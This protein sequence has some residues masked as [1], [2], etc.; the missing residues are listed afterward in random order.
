MPMRLEV[1]P[2]DLAGVRVGPALG[3]FAETLLALGV[4]RSPRTPLRLHG[5]WEAIAPSVTGPERALASYL[6]LSASVGL[7]LFT[8]LPPTATVSEGRAALA[9]AAPDVLATE[10]DTWAHTRDHAR[11]LGL[12]P[13][14]GP[15][16]RLALAALRDGHGA[17]RDALISTIA[18]FHRSGLA[19]Y[20]P[21]VD[22]QLARE[23]ARL[24]EQLS[25]GG[26]QALV[27]SMGPAVRW[28]ESSIDF[29]LVGVT[30]ACVNRRSLGGRG[31]VV[32]PSFFA[33]EPATYWPADA[34][35][36]VLLIVPVALIDRASL[37]HT[38]GTPQPGA[39]LLG[40]TRAAILEA[41]ARGPRSTSELGAELGIAVSGASQH[42][43]VLR[44]AGLITS[45]RDGGRVLH[46]TT[47]LGETL[48]AQLAR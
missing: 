42:A 20:W 36:P 4:V 21:A 41:V 2:A 12:L 9:D 1:T 25:S 23:Q 7:D 44:E 5:W 35:Q 38:A 29:Q 10:A 19:D 48:L 17:S 15:T 43:A 18:A 14:P 27:R 46:A 34:D 45:T 30:D 28:N 47:E 22:D 16:D 26:V 31:L 39:E 32:T 8:A 33:L 37:P 40:R 11:R 3:P 24:T 6:W 13:R